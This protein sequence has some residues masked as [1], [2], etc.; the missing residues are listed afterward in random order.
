MSLYGS[1]KLAS[2][3]LALEYGQAFGFPVWINRCGV[4][5]GGG[6]FGKADQG[7]FAFWLHS[8]KEGRPLKY[9]GFGG[10]GHQ[11]RDNLHPRDLVPLLLKQIASSN[12]TSRPRVVNVSGGLASAM[13]LA[14]LSDWCARRWGQRTV[15]T[16]SSPRPFDLP[17]VVLDHRL[18][19]AAWDW[20]PET[21]ATEILSEIADF[22]DAH[23]D[24]IDVSK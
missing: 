21:S 24:W 11:V 19:S 18:A 7:I 9:I 8:W 14:Q 22:A 5:A 6:Q 10:H 4:M 23:P 15:G 12:E 20:Q 13:S 17:W 1:T 2:E 3:L 16:D